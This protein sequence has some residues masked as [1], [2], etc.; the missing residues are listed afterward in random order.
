MG[1]NRW[2]RYFSFDLQDY[3]FYFLDVMKSEKAY[4]YT[5][6]HTLS[7]PSRIN[8]HPN[9]EK[10]KSGKVLLYFHK[11]QK[12][13]VQTSPSLKLVETCWQ[14]CH[15]LSEALCPLKPEGFPPCSAIPDYTLT[16]PHF[17]TTTE[18]QLWHGMLGYTA[19][20][21]LKVML[22]AFGKLH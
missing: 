22:I 8:N 5:G 19:I 7:G 20:L 2:E 1:L 12:V 14:E 11:L 21:I 17:M 13:L 3:L 4:G 10:L 18:A 9:T 16:L 6:S 15:V